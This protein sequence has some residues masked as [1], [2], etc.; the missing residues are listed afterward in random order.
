VF[1]LVAGTAEEPS[2]IY[3]FVLAHGFDEGAGHR[4]QLKQ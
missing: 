3:H 4:P 1:E 2:P